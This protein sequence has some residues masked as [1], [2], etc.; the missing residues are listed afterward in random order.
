MALIKHQSKC[1]IV[2]RNIFR[3]FQNLAEHDLVFRMKEDLGC[4]SSERSLR[5]VFAD[6]KGS[7]RPGG[8]S[9][10]GP[11]SPGGGGAA[12]GENNLSRSGSTDVILRRFPLKFVD[13]GLEDLFAAN[14]NRWMTT[15]LILMGVL[16]LVVT[17]IMWPLMAW[18]FNMQ[19]AFNHDEPLGILFHSDMAVTVFVSVLFIVVKIFRPLA[20]HAE[21][22]ADIGTFLVRK[23]RTSSS[24]S[25]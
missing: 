8:G 23:N 15:R 20:H 11:G 21:L 22:I 19:D 14:I 4:G 10:G 18:S 17:S 3:A 5:S 16:M 24:S 7:L 6:S 12:G 25:A 13:A 1:G 9:I 2:T